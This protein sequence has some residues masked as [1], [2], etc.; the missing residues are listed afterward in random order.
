MVELNKI[1][2]KIDEDKDNLKLKVTKIF[3]KLKN[4]INNRE[5]EIL[6]DIDKKFNEFIFDEKILKQSEKLPVQVKEFIEKG[7]IIEN[8]WKK[9]NKKLN[10]LINKCINVENNI[11]NIKIIN[12]NIA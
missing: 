2:E 9:D 5:D 12:E 10:I 4:A 8:E 7:K 1:I 3:T 6:A 11:N